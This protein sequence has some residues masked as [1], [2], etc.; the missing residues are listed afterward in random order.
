MAVYNGPVCRLCRRD[1]VKL[2][3]KG[4]RCYTSKC[5][6]DR[7]KYPPGQHGQKQRKLAEYAQQLREKQKL[8]R[9]YRILERQFRNYFQEATRRKGGRDAA[10]VAGAASR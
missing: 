6:I 5:A 7:R 3:L 4:E 8:K 2:Y 1:G 10:S 9:M